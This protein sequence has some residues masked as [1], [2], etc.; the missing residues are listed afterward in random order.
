ME[1]ERGHRDT[2]EAGR[3]SWAHDKWIRRIAES[4]LYHRAGYCL[5][6][7]ATGEGEG[8][9]KIIRRLMVARL[10]RLKCLEGLLCPT[11]SL[12]GRTQ[13]CCQC[14]RSLPSAG[15]KWQGSPQPTARPG[16][17]PATAFLPFVRL[18]F[19]GSSLSSC[20]LFHRHNKC[21]GC[22]FFFL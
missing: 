22:F 12:A 7:K 20:L 21:S 13:G 4:F 18:S 5:L 1:Q 9:D 15:C 14:L 19:H 11:E 17:G 10:L 16:P 6:I 3:T 2:D 8:G